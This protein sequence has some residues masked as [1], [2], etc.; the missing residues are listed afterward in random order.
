MLASMSPT[1]LPPDRFASLATLRDSGWR[2]ST[3]DAHT[4]LV[5][6]I[7]NDV[8]S[9]VDRGIYLC[10]TGKIRC[11]EGDNYRELPL[12]DL[13]QLYR[14][15][16]RDFLQRIGGAFAFVLIDSEAQACYAVT[17][18]FATVPMYYT[19][20][21]GPSVVVA[22][23]LAAV[24]MLDANRLREPDPQAIYNYVYHQMIPSP[25]TIYRDIRKLGPAQV[26]IV[27]NGDRRVETYWEPKF[28]EKLQTSERELAQRLQTLLQQT[29][30]RA[31]DARPTA[32]FLSGG[33]D[34]S[35]V[36][37]M[38]ARNRSAPVT[39]YSIG[40]SLPGYD[41]ME[42]ARITARRFGLDHREYYLQSK[43]LIELMPAMAAA[44][45]EP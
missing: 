33:I 23:S 38:L 40:F 36:C 10:V 12:A 22:N 44:Y 25:Q 20:A 11:N 14:T 16:G 32:C 7:G 15:R 43:E 9:I 28:G 5:A 13:I 1:G 34:S 3:N 31:S 35:T 8:T 26:L 4:A 39:A 19:N 29:V 6:G 37:G 27:K 42:Y 17:D 24:G 18:K 30:V 21:A 2:I 45:D 41:E